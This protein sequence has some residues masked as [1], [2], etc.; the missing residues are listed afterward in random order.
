[1][2]HEYLLAYGV[3]GDFGRFRSPRPLAC[4]RGDRAVIRTA[5]GLEIGTVLREAAA[6]HAHFLPNTTVGSLLR[7]STADDEQ[8]AARLQARTAGFCDEAGR[9][10][11]TLG[12]PLAVL[13]AEMLL[14]GEHAVLHFVRWQ[15][16]DIRPLVSSLSKQF[17][18]SV[19]VQDLTH[20]PEEKHGCGDC[21]HGG[22]GHCGEGG[23]G[24]C[25]SCGSA[26][27]AE[28][29]AYF[30]GL[31]EKMEQQNRVPLL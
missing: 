11:G 18:L 7:L 8:S 4:G 26:K 12:L 15:D 21:G 20:A 29:Q 23:C 5:R 3:L 6:G 13:D 25:G 31:R 24:S 16:C 22:C 9:T 28:V 27:P 1:M 14:D 17:A 2:N 10:A 30:A 19:L